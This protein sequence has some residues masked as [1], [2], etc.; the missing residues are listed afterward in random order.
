MSIL[1]DRAIRLALKN[2]TISIDPPPEDWQFQPA[3]VELT[4][5]GDFVEPYQN[6]RMSH[7]TGYT[8]LPSECV[9][10]TTQQ[11]I[12]LAPTVVGRVE[13]KSSWGRRFILT[14]VTAGYVDPGFRGQLTLE[15]HNLSRVSQFL[16]VGTPIAQLSF[17]WTD[18]E[19]DRPYGHPELNSHYQDQSGTTPSALPWR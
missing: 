2:K 3:S 17:Q 19:A 7:G 16:A 5:G 11:T 18:F 13:G 4:L 14:H 6:T 15:L 12:E 1:A 10:A 9:L 8:L